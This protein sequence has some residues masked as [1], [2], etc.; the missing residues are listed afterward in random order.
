MFP[1]RMEVGTRK[2]NRRT[3]Y[4]IRTAVRR[5][6]IRSVENDR[7]R[8]PS[9]PI[10]RVLCGGFPRPAIISLGTRVATRLQQPTR[11]SDGPSRTALPRR[12]I[13]SVWPCS[14]RGLPDRPPF[15]G[16][17]WSL[18]PPFHP[19]PSVSQ[20]HPCCQ[21]RKSGGAGTALLCG[22]DPA[23]CPALGITRRRALWSADFPRSRNGDRDRPADL[24]TRNTITWNAYEKEWRESANK[25]S[26]RKLKRLK[27]H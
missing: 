6:T 18:T 25:C 23:G 9:R 12:G 27:R 20:F 1:V 13:T 15:G 8:H 2:N 4:G 22:P 3:K 17:R 16:R 7:S 19:R 24:D 10:S 14:R 21:G 5:P 11:G 26:Y